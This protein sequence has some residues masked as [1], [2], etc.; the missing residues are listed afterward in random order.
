MTHVDSCN[1]DEFGDD[2][3]EPGCEVCGAV[4]EDRDVD[5]AMRAM[6]GWVCTSCLNKERMEGII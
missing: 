3:V 2:V 1:N 5:N 4:M 6:S